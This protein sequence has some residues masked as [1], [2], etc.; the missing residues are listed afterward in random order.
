MN[1]AL[2][3]SGGIGT[4]MRQDGFPKQY[5]EVHGKPILMYTIDKFEKCEDIDRIVVVAAPA[6]QPKIKEWFKQYGV[7]KFDSFA[8]PG[9]DRQS[10]ICNGL[11]SCMAASASEEDCVIIHDAVRP[12]VSENLI[13]ACLAALQDHDGCMP[14]LPVT[15]TVYQSQ[16]GKSISAL[17]DRAT[18]FAGQAPEAFRLWKYA[19]INRRATPQ[20]LAAS[21]GTSVLAFEHGLDVA[22]IRG[23]DTNFKITT[24]A[25]LQRFEMIVEDML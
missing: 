4:R 10:S 14:G 2:I 23:E 12:L 5:L 17:L 7:Q 11:E 19:E 18:L 15:D 25:D 21:L 24:P 3:L 16:D 22:L 20:E 13:S 1:Y 8:Q 9:P 6:W